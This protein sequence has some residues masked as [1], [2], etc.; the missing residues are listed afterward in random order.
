MPLPR[1]SRLDLYEIITPL[2]AGGMGEVYR[3]RDTALKRDVAI[4]V[5]HDGW[6]RD[7]ERIHRFE[8]EAQ[9]A[10]ALNHPN[11]I[12]IFH[13]GRHNGS[14]Y[15]VTELL[16]GETLRERLQRGPLPLREVLDLGI[17]I[18]RGLAA[19]C[20]VGIIH[21][22][23][24]PE[25]IFLTKDGSIKILDFGLAKLDPAK[26][27]NTEGETVTLQ[28][29]IPG[30]VLGTVGY[31]S[32]EQVRGTA[33][34]ARSDIFALG[35]I[36]Y[37][38]LT[39]RRAFQQPT[40]AETMSAI[41]NEEPSQ[42]SQ[43]APATP[44]ALQHIV[45][46]CFEK[47]ADK[48]FQNASDLAFALEVLSG[49]S[50]T[51][52]QATTQVASA[53]K[54]SW[55]TRALLAAIAVI[56]VGGLSAL[57]WTAWLSRSTKPSALL[58]MRLELR[59]PSAVGFALS[60]NGE[61]IAYVA[62]GEAGRN[63]VWIRALNSLDSRALPG[64]EDVTNPLVFWSFDSQYVGFQ[65]GN[66]LKKIRVA[67]TKPPQVV[68]EVRTFV[69][70]GAWNRADVIVFGATDGIMQVSAAGGVPKFVTAVH[71]I[72]YTGAHVFPRF[73]PDGR[74]FIYLNAEERPGVYV[75]SLDVM[76]EH[77]STKRIVETGVMAAFVAPHNGA[78]G[79][80]LFMHEDSLFAQDFDPR[81]L[82]L[83][84]EPVPLANHVAKF[85]LSA[86]YSASETGI[87][88]YRTALRT[89][90]LTWFDRQGKELGN[91]RESAP[92][93][94]VDD[95]SLSPNGIQLVTTRIDP[96][97]KDLGVALW[98]TDLPRGVST[99]LSFE[100]VPQGS[101]VWSAD[102][103]YLAFGTTRPGGMAIIQKPSNGSG[104]EHLL[105]AAS[106]DEKYPNDWSANSQA[107]LYTRQESG[108]DTGLWLA[109]LSR[110]A[111]QPGTVRPLIDTAF[112]E[113]HGQFSPDGRWI[114]YASDESGRWEIYVQSFTN[115]KEPETKMQVSRDGGL[116]PR[117]RRDGRE[118]FYI[119]G[120]GKLM[121][122]GITSG[123]TFHAEAPQ[124]LFQVKDISR[125]PDRFEV[126]SWAVSSDGKRFLIS[127][128]LPS[129]E[130][131]SVVLNWPAEMKE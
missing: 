103:R 38:M 36:F 24:K 119:S 3:A 34:D 114:A 78:P 95:V 73:L 26:T 62:P 2:G 56:V 46:R 104:A 126:F 40:S 70:G 33:A 10:A 61:Q 45:H 20:A 67:G 29:T 97:A 77:Q 44:T 84:G 66:T 54:T 5:L 111:D 86:G 102:G 130:P 41:L 129:T 105:V 115:S 53:R 63:V 91:L 87:L 28:Q 49:L 8:I 79:R 90:Q 127:R 110:N 31:M 48:R 4:K 80:L 6:S 72:H 64:S 55:R 59:L 27:A 47:N 71:G 125:K 131:V 60:P 57:R 109:D 52:L 13:V 107:L 32:P 100:K 93:G 18:A 58:P 75:G 124:P 68:C 65:A 123:S 76:P 116:E 101:P 83:T 69:L 108:K 118:L 43:L 11:I 42:I 15:I 7:P 89:S 112:N 17:G 120:D 117:W 25:N 94:Y 82:E 96:I 128:D 50:S 81:R 1:G 30:Q 92:P 51:S 113:A 12:S 122:V 39:G 19:A 21:R 106:P 22:D 121:S 35:L 85:L 98:V 99:R 74:Q 37:E 16:Q 88:A 23:L 14:P 9:A